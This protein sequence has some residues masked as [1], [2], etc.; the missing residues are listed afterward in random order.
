MTYPK[1]ATADDL[2]E[3]QR[4][5]QQ[6]HAFDPLKRIREQYGIITKE[7]RQ[8]L[9]I[10]VA[11]A[12]DEAK[13]AEIEIAKLCS[14]IDHMKAMKAEAL[15]AMCLGKA[16]IAPINTLPDEV[17]TQ[18]LTLTNLRVHF[19]S[20]QKSPDFWRIPQRSEIPALEL[21]RVCSRWERL[22]N[23]QSV[24]WSSIIINLFGNNLEPS[25]IEK[26]KRVLEKSKEG[27]LDLTVVISGGEGGLV[28]PTVFP[29][30]IGCSHRWRSLE[31][32]CPPIL[33]LTLFQRITGLPAL[34]DVCLIMLRHESKTRDTIPVPPS[35]LKIPSPNVRSVIIEQHHLNS[36]HNLSIVVPCHMARRISL[37]V[38][39]VADFLEAI[40]QSI[41]LRKAEL[42][43]CYIEP[44]PQR[45]NHRLFSS[46]SSNLVSLR[47]R[48]SSGAEYDA[49]ASCF[50]MLTAPRL[51]ELIVSAEINGKYYNTPD[52]P[53]AAFSSFVHRSNC[54]LRTLEISYVPLSDNS[55][56]HILEEL[57]A[58]TYLSIAE[59]DRDVFGC[60]T[61]GTFL[62]YGKEALKISAVTN[63]LLDRLHVDSNDPFLKN[64]RELQFI[65]KGK[66]EELCMLKFQD[67]IQSRWQNECVSSLRAVTLC[68]TSRELEVTVQS[69]LQDRFAGIDITV[70][71][72]DDAYNTDE[73]K[74]D[75]EEVE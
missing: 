2:P 10:L 68:L 50:E 13:R 61:G 29:L 17:L 41:Y 24:F 63:R 60:Y 22:V 56:L 65:A 39:H 53:I 44:D 1:L 11:G 36:D 26:L 75:E 14:A 8:Q 67:M 46:V 66:K 69:G 31:L 71:G 16:L 73:D 49:M 59:P 21:L 57:P 20:P 4:A 58:L 38:N 72:N 35:T 5:S 51:E 48:L 3:F 7:E 34:K 54:R 18:I 15:A 45:P 23:S 19:S 64:L 42:S 25:Q 37:C 6:I 9:S 40:A 47:F 70:S 12:G 28:N 30:I 74:D 43:S 62:P 55:L 32:A 33:H 27:E 52:W